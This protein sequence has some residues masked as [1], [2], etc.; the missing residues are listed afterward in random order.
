MASTARALWTH[1]TT[2]ALGSAAALFVVALLAVL[3][4]RAASGW[5]GEA[6]TGWVVLAVLL[7]SLAPVALLVLD[8]LAER[9]AILGTKWFN[10]DLSR[11]DLARTAS[12]ELAVLPANLGVTGPVVSDTAPMDIMAALTAAIR[13]DIVVVDIRD[14]DAW[15]V[16]R[17]LAFAAGAVRRGAPE[18]IVF[19]G[20]RGNRPGQF[21]GW[22]PPREVLDAILREPRGY[23]ER[24]ERGLAIARQLTLSKFLPQVVAPGGASLALHPDIQRYTVAPH[25]YSGLGDA[26]VEQVVMDQLGNQMAPGGSLEAPPDRLTLARLQELFAPVLVTE[27]V[28]V[29]ASGAVQTD[30]VLAARGSFI[31]LVRD[32]T[33]VSMLRSADAQRAILRQLV[34]QRERG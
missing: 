29:E 4:V 12:E 2:A 25:D 7:L 17:L 3:I 9:R 14:G 15:W 22:A 34:G 32:G 27:S 18:A 28:D 10:L 31:A 13:H 5:P 30:A 8:F 33:F 19:V 26:A 21:L 16:T 6:A 1:G 11:V 20:R 23:A 24:Y